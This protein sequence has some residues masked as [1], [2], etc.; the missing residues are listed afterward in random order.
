MFAVAVAACVAAAF[1]P[2]VVHAQPLPQ[3]R[4]VQL[5]NGLTL[6]FRHNPAAETVA[7]GAFVKV[8]ASC[9]TAETAGIRGVVQSMLLHR[10]AE[11]DRADPVQQLAEWGA[12]VSQSVQF[13][14]TQLRL[15]TLAEHFDKSLLP[16]REILMGARFNWSE[17]AAVRAAQQQMLVAAEETSVAYA[18]QLGFSH[19]FSGTPCAWPPTARPPAWTGTTTTPTMTTSASCSTAGRCPRR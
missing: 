10:P 3:T 6:L 13:D 4:R 9:E 14:C 11:A 18:S 7:I 2:A 8:P 1:A 5:D 16:L 15:L 12:V 17:L 19:L